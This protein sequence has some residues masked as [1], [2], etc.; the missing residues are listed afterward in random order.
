[1]SMSSFLASLLVDA[2]VLFSELP[3]VAGYAIRR[4]SSMR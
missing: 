3:T 1:M 2:I 4:S